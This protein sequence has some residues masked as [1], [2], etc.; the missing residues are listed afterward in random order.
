MLRAFRAERSPLTNG[1]LV[2][3]TGLSKATVSR[4]TTTLVG[5]GYLRRVAGGPQF[6]LATAAL[7]IGHTY[8]ET[9]PVTQR[10]H[11]FM[12]ELADRLNVSVSLAAPDHL[13]MLYIAH[14]TSARIATLRMGVGSLLPMGWTA[15][16]RAWLWGLPPDAQG[17]YIETL[18]Q[19]AGPRAGELEKGIQAAFDDLQTTGACMSLGNFQRNAYGI[20][21]P[22]RVGH[23]ATHLALSCGAVE[24]EPDVAALRKRIV[25]VLQAAALDLVALLRDVDAQL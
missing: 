11:P 13:D 22:V 3:R 10:A 7:S 14:R 25:P 19:A 2:R 5:L 4:L 23:S 6:A 24:L 16:G 18:K 1:E 8:L 9:N 17:N 21:L 20:A 15:S 12:Q